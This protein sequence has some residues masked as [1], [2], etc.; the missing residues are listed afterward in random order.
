MRGGGGL[1]GLGQRVLY[2]CAHGAQINFGNLTPYLAFDI[3]SES[4]NCTVYVLFPEISVNPRLDINLF[5]KC[6]NILMHSNV[7]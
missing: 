3:H 5:V 7:M 1:R 2:S 6:C 4:M